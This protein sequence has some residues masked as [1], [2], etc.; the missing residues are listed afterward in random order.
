M[1]LLLKQAK[2]DER[3]KKKYNSKKLKILEEFIEEE[4]VHNIEN[5][6]RYL[7]LV[8]NRKFS[9]LETFLFARVLWGRNLNAINANDGQLDMRHLKAG[10]INMS[11]LVIHIRKNRSYLTDDLVKLMEHHTKIIREHLEYFSMIS[12]MH[13]YDINHYDY[14]I[15]WFKNCFIM[16]NNKITD[17]EYIISKIEEIKD[18][19]LTKKINTIMFDYDKLNE[20]ISKISIDKFF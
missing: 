19:V 8:I 10:V 1:S 12:S 2:S 3:K 15:E 6:L 13:I 17:Q 18:F 11:C 9:R 5:Y 4:D 14:C 20:S 7:L 16:L